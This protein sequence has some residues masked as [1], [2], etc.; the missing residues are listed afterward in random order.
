MQ[1]FEKPTEVGLIQSNQVNRETSRVREGGNR[2]ERAAGWNPDLK[3][4][5][6]CRAEWQGSGPGEPAKSQLGLRGWGCGYLA[7]GRATTT[8][9]GHV[10]EPFHTGSIVISQQ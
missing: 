8:H 7:W 4:R 1:I 6:S 2:K 9:I 10:A 3:R 5:L